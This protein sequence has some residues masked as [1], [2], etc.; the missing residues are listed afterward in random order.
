MICFHKIYATQGN[1]EIDDVDYRSVDDFGHDPEARQED[2]EEDEKVLEE[3][4]DK[5]LLARISAIEAENHNLKE[6]VGGTTS[7]I[8]LRKLFA[9][10]VGFSKSWLDL[11]KVVLASDTSNSLNP[12]I[13]KII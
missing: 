10:A 12:E 5:Q 7:C 4:E 1:E 2:D 13:K 9:V 11:R 8:Q 3:L 6:Q